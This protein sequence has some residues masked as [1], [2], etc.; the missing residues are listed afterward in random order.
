MSA[1]VDHRKAWVRRT[2]AARRKGSA[3]QLLNWV[4][5]VRKGTS[6]STTPLHVLRCKTLRPAPCVEISPSTPCTSVPT[7]SSIRPRLCIGCRACLG[8]PYYSLSSTRKGVAG[9]PLLR[10]RT[11]L[12][13]EPAC[14]IVCPSEACLGRRERPRIAYARLIA[15]RTRTAQARQ[16]HSARLVRRCF[17]GILVPGARTG[18]DLPGRTQVHAAPSPGRSSGAR[19]CD[20]DVPHPPAWGGTCGPYLVTKTCPPAPLGLRSCPGWVW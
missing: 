10:A 5:N 19:C 9:K 15:T 4:S 20:A 16:E 6:P 3:R 8:C 13:L 2:V 17:A 11:E 7:R 12:G 1:S 18:F 14:V